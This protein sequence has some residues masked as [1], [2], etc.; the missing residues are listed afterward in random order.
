MTVFRHSGKLG[1]IIFSLPVVRRLG[2]GHLVLDIG[3]ID[4]GQPRLTISGFETIKPLLEYQNY[5]HSV[6]IYDGGPVDVDLDT[7]RSVIPWSGCNLV[8][9]NY[10]AQGLE[11]DLANDVIPWLE[12]PLILGNGEKQVIVSRTGRHLGDDSKAREFYGDLFHQGLSKSGVFIGFQDEHS[13]FESLFGFKI[14]HSQFSSALDIAMALKNSSLWVGNENFVGSIAEGLKITAIREIRNTDS[15][16]KMYCAFQ[17][18][19]LFYI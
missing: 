4:N 6:S 18:A 19:N 9:A 5:I 10:R 11:D 14:R 3:I 1:D 16:E 12:A 17:R 2:G 13:L 15:P 7:F 8:N